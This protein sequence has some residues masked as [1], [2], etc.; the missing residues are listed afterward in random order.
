MIDLLVTFT[1]AYGKGCLLGLILAAMCAATMVFIIQPIFL[2]WLKEKIQMWLGIPDLQSCI[3]EV[4]QKQ[5]KIGPDVMQLKYDIRKAEQ[6]IRERTDVHTDIHYKAPSTII[7]IG[8]YRNKDYVKVFNME[9]REWIPILE[10]LR[11]MQKY[12]IINRIDAPPHLDVVLKREL[13]KW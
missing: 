9:E 4:F 12:G 10:G 13:E 3:N 6:V 7:M 5:N 8:K 11:N 1:M 2:P